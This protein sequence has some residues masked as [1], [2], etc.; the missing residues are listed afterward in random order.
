MLVV[1]FFFVSLFTLS[2]N[3]DSSDWFKLQHLSN[4]KTSLRSKTAYNTNRRRQIIIRL[5]IV[6]ADYLKTIARHA[7]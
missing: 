4:R 7:I 1:L 6:A 2:D 3:S 5:T